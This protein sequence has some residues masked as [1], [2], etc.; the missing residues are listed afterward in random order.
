MQYI[1]F[2]AA[3]ISIPGAVP[4]LGIEPA[5]HHRA[6]PANPAGSLHLRFYQDTRAYDRGFQASYDEPMEDSAVDPKYGKW[7][8]ATIWTG[9]FVGSWAVVIG[10]VLIARA[11]LP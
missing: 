10:C 3:R 2:E 5:I 7:K 6:E 9:A 11:L 4:R 8:L 1:S